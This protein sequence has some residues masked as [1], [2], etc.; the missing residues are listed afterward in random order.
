MKHLF[1][2]SAALL[3]L[4]PLAASAD[5]LPDGMHPV[6]NNVIVD[7]AETYSGYTI[8][9]TGDERGPAAEKVTSNQS[10]EF[11]FSGDVHLIAVKKA[12]AS[13]I[14]SGVDSQCPE[15]GDNW[16][17]LP[18]NQS[19]IAS[20]NVTF[21]MNSIVPDVNP[22]VKETFLI[23]IDSLSDAGMKAH[24]VSDVTED[25]SGNQ[26]AKAVP[27]V[28][29]TPAPTPA[30]APTPTPIDANSNPMPI[31]SPAPAPDTQTIANPV[32]PSVP[33]TPASDTSSQ[34]PL[35]AAIIV[36][37]GAVGIVFASKTWKK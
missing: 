27:A 13:K 22:Q 21:S 26:A 12:D 34:V 15:C 33:V 23:H 36:C 20:S 30:P 25:K 16:F 11:N 8:Y 24:L 29:P 37:L 31:P 9:L 4:S 1:A 2:L 19:L 32:A 14:K 28:A 10:A 17:N 35:I 6:T 7:D 5:V 3:V 18:V